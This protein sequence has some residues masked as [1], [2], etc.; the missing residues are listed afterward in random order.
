MSRTPACRPLPFRCGGFS[1]VAGLRWLHKQRIHMC[2]MRKHSAHD[3]CDK[4]A[5][6][7]IEYA[8]MLYHHVVTCLMPHW[9]HLH[10]VCDGFKIVY[11]LHSGARN[12]VT[13]SR[14]LS[15]GKVLGAIPGHCPVMRKRRRLSKRGHDTKVSPHGQPELYTV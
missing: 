12:H 8:L 6:T 1:K 13:D 9:K 10:T 14:F 2:L 11:R 3:I 15:Q 4:H 7:I 5:P